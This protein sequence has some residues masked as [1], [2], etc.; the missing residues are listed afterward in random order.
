MCE[1]GKR[2]DEKAKSISPAPLDGD[3]IPDARE[4]PLQESIMIPKREGSVAG[5]ERHMGRTHR[6]GKSAG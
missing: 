4:E 3:T 2:R 6:S 1:R 5:A